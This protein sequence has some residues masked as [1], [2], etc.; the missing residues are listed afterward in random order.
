MC[1]VRL[2]LFRRS[3]VKCTMFACMCAGAH[4]QQTCGDLRW[5]KQDSNACWVF[6]EVLART[7]VQWRSRAGSDIIS[8]AQGP[9]AYLSAANFTCKRPLRS[10]GRKSLPRLT[11]AGGLTHGKSS[12]IKQTPNSALRL[13]LPDWILLFWL[14]DGRIMESGRGGECR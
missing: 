1:A 14:S 10:E 6:V 9:C 12:A 11:A 3:R 13:E 7:Q 5:T 2:C 8:S 4:L